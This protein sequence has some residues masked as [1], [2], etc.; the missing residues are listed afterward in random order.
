MDARTTHF[1]KHYLLVA[2]GLQLGI[3]GLLGVDVV[4][5]LFQDAPY[6]VRIF[7]LAVGIAA[8]LNIVTH[9]SN[10]R[11]CNTAPIAKKKRK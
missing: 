1:V 2:G 4:S 9:S 8:V 3:L 10:C 7:Y 6:M 5:R 11:L